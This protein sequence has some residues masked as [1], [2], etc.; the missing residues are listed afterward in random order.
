MPQDYA[1]EASA[2]QAIGTDILDGHREQQREFNRV[3]EAIALT[4][5]AAAG[6]MVIE[7]FLGNDYKGRVTNTRTGTVILD[8][9]DWKPLGQGGRGLVV[10]A[11]Q[12]IHA[13]VSDAGATNI[14]RFHFITRP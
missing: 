10:P 7:L 9:A 3:I 14:G 12:K 5:S 6:D 11:N 4:G 2:G 13:F 1:D 8:L